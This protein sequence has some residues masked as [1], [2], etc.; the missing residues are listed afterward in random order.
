MPRPKPWEAVAGPANTSLPSTTSAGA[1]TSGTTSSNFLGGGYANRYGSSYGSSFGAGYGGYGAGIGG[2][3]GGYSGMPRLG[4]GFYGGGIGGPFGALGADPDKD[5]MPPGLRQFEQLL[6]SVGRITQM[7]EMNFEVLQHFLTSLV[8]LI[9]RVRALY[10]DAR[11]LT[12]RLCRQ[13]LEFGESSMSTMQ[14]AQSRVRRHPITACG[15]IV[16]CLSILLRLRQR[17]TLNGDREVYLGSWGAG[18]GR[19]VYCGDAQRRLARRR[20]GGRRGPGG[21]RRG[22]RRGIYLFR[23]SCMQI[24]LPRSSG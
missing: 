10:G 14:E 15:L 18:S 7:L 8:G 20:I 23:V 12:S 24:Q 6:F 1:A 4:G 5:M 9:E 13:S 22:G 2:Y 21:F 11:Q 3:G 16:L 17:L 19:L